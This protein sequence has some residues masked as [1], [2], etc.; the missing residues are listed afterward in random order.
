MG[1]TTVVNL[2][3]EEEIYKALPVFLESLRDG[4][5]PRPDKHKI[6][7]YTRRNQAR[8]LAQSLS[9]LK[10]VGSAKELDASNH[11]VR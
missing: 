7:R 1:G 5:H 9:E 2:L 10:E 8:T 11:L 3:D 4:T 6:L